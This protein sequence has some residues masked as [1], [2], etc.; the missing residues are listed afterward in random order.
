MFHRSGLA[1]LAG[2]PD[3]RTVVNRAVTGEAASSLA[4]AVYLHRLRAQIAAMAAALGGLDTL[5]FT[6]RVGERSATV[7]AGATDGLGFLGVGIDPAR[8]VAHA[9]GDHDITAAGSPARTLVVE[10]RED[11]EIARSVRVCLAGQFPR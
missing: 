8:N 5:V 2:T 10:A 3:M 1:A 4:L 11:L 9:D 6:G 7:R